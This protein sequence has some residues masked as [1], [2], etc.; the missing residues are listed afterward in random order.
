MNRSKRRD[1]FMVIVIASGFAIPARL[2]AQAL[3]PQTVQ[4]FDCYIQS[5]ET[6]MNGRQQFL[7]ADAD[8]ALNEQLV[9]GQRIQTA[10]ASGP[11]PHRV[12]GGLIHDWI[13][14]VFI[15]GTTLERVI[16]MLQDYDHRAQYFPEVISASKLL[17]RTGEHYRFTMRMKEPAVIDVDSDVVYERVDARRWRCRSYSTEIR[18]VGKDQRYVL[19]LYSYWRF[20]E[21]PQGVYVEGESITL[22][23]EFSSLARTFG[24]MIGISPEK[25]LK[26]T[27]ESMRE[28]VRKP[29]QEFALPPAGLPACGEAFRPGGCASMTKAGSS[30]ATP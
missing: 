4:A 3:K 15:P 12:E 24:S 6:R 9:R 28:S 26:R 16:R 18:P 1:L 14:S 10:P 2:P 30:S 27:L 5:A 29:G 25:S 8:T 20:A 11:S 21:A 13:G 19:R 22:S 17:C 7:L 23:G